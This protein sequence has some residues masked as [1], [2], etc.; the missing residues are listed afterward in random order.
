MK[1]KAF[2]RGPVS[3]TDINK[4]IGYLSSENLVEKLEGIISIRRLVSINSSENERI[5]Q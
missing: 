2:Q 4:F 1:I 3:P 5:S